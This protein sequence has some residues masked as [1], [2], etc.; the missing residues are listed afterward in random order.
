MA[1]SGKKIFMELRHLTPLAID[2]GF[3]PRES[4]AIFR[5]W[6]R[7]KGVSGSRRPAIEANVR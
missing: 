6:L 4:G 2:R 7:A 3:A 5:E 1:L